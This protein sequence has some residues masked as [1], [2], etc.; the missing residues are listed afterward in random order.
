MTTFA[1]LGIRP[2][3]VT[4]LESLGF[5][6]PTPVQERII[7]ILLDKP[8]DIV[9]LAQ[10]GTGKTAAFGIPLVQR[11]D[12]AERH[13]QALV[14]CP[15]RE[16]CMQ[17]ARDLTAFGANL[18]GLRIRAVYGGANIDNQIRGLR[19]GAQVVVATPGR[20]TDL[21]RR[22]E[23]DLSAI[24]ALVLDEADEMMQMGF[25]DDLDAILA[26]TP[27]EK[28]TLLFSATMPRGVATLTG[29]YMRAPME[30]TVGDR[31]AG[32]E[33][34]RHLYYMTHAKD[35]YQAMR[36]LIDATPEIYGII[37]CRTRQEAND[38]AEK[39]SK[40][41][42]NADA[43]HGDLSQAQRDYVMQ[44]FRDRSLRLLVATDV[45][46]RGLDVNNLTH[47]I[48]YNLP[49]DI[50]N[51]TH[52]S[53]RTGRAGKTGVSIALINMRE[54]F[55]IREIEN[56]LKRQFEAGRI[57]SGHEVCREQLLHRLATITKETPDQTRL[58]P[59]RE[60][61]TEALA[62]L[63]RE[64][65]IDRL[66]SL[67]LSRFL[68]RYQNAPDLNV[69]EK[70]RGHEER[71]ARREPGGY[72]GPTGNRVRFNRFYLNVGQKDGLYPSRLIG[73]INEATGSTAIKI[74][75]IEIL[76]HSAMLEADS[77]HSRA[78]TEIFNGV[79]INGREVTVK[80]VE[81]AGPRP[82]RPAEKAGA[83]KGRKWERPAPPAGR[84][85]AKGK[86]RKW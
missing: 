20:L 2:E 5:S 1:E 51:Y 4:A 49:D 34:V 69:A 85:F 22:H 13:P 47:V 23:I 73:Q 75:R 55:L 61:I 60:E 10:T 80:M 72:G 50:A 71:D 6:N 7:P 28:H 30:I 35:R 8:V 57:P 12:L 64:A 58:A 36:R 3:I 81:G 63:D 48:N 54:R 65:L 29:K 78:I 76:D 32:T 46:A 67:E 33:N 83:H 38:I 18:P 59:F 45:A 70:P 17:V 68:T 52:R 84:P 31:N 24:S 66:V 21:M 74:G 19:Q 86:K 39:L 16:L 56:K 79:R 82:H 43:L 77:A 44:R 41:G 37:F 40:D 14:L 27:P 62:D 42:Y 11:C 25:Q 53:G 26:K 15:T 9:G